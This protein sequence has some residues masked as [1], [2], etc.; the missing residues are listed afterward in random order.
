[1][2]MKYKCKIYTKIRSEKLSSE[3]TQFHEELTEIIRIR[4]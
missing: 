2:W 3:I 4:W 1:M